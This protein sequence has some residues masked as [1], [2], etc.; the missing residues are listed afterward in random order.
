[1]NYCNTF[2]IQQQ[3]ASDG[4]RHSDDVPRSG[5]P[6]IQPFRLRAKFPAGRFAFKFRFDS[7]A[8]SYGFVRRRIRFVQPDARLGMDCI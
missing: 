2:R 7:S 6:A 5:H 4:Q 3:D 8:T 1:M